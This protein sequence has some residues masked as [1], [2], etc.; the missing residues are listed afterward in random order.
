MLVV[1]I[2]PL[3]CHY[4]DEMLLTILMQSLGRNNFG[5]KFEGES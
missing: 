3:V 4:R 2:F 5:G 1:N